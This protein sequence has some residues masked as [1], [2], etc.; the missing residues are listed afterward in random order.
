MI[1]HLKPRDK[2][3]IFQNKIKDIQ[4]RIRMH[5]TYGALSVVPPDTANIHHRNNY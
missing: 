5:S 3:E 4:T 2:E 1:K